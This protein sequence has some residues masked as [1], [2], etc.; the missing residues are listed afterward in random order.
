MFWN[1]RECRQG[2][3]HGGGEGGHT[4]LHTWTG[5]G[6]KTVLWDGQGR[7][8]RLSLWRSSL[9]VV[10]VWMLNGG[11]RS[12]NAAPWVLTPRA[13]IAQIY[14][15]NVGLAPAGQ[16]QS[17]SVT[18]LTPGFSLSRN[19]RNL[20]LAFDYNL[21]TLYRWQEDV[22]DVNHQFAGTAQARLVERWLFLD[23][24]TTFN[25]QNLLATELGGD[26]IAARG[27]RTDVFT[28]SVSP[29]V[30]HRFGTS[31][32]LLLRYQFAGVENFQ[33]FDSTSQAISAELASGADFARSPW[34]VLYTWRKSIPSEGESS[35]TQRVS[36]RLGY[37]INP[38][39]EVFGQAGYEIDEFATQRPASELEGP[40]WSVGA[41]WAPNRRTRLEGGYGERPFGQT[42]FLDLSYRRRRGAL[43][44]SY[45]EDF[46]T[47]TQAQLETQVEEIDPITG[48]LAFGAVPPPSLIVEQ[49][50]LQKRLQGEA[51]YIFRRRTTGNLSLF[52]EEREFETTGDQ[53]RVYGGDVQLNRAL[54]RQNSLNL[55]GGVQRIRD[56]ATDVENTLW[57]AGIQLS[58]VG[59]RYVTSS[60]EYRYQQQE[61]DVPA[62]D[63]SENRI[64]LRVTITFQPRKL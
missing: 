39:L 60:L 44:L 10:V 8:E 23:L 5:S 31:V 18:E 38:R 13:S 27:E 29:F 57:R 58:R 21:Q 45:S 12:A 26:N 56:S 63:Y 32:D 3:V 9:I 6:C 52:A 1:R 28:Y 42:Y 24:A 34:S 55:L 15:D 22:T 17:Q 49:V 25:Q 14:T 54:S 43:R 20:R 62:S 16:E 41:L 11:L 51:T 33:T 19:T 7:R 37:R 35:E 47:T 40:T 64:T 50:F 48:Q 30:D 46:A 59:N 4:G 2:K 53:Q 61:S 36:G